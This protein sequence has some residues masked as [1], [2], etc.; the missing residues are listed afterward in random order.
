MLVI[1]FPYCP[2]ILLDDNFIV[3]KGYQPKKCILDRRG[4]G[5]IFTLCLHIYID[6]RADQ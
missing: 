6:R 2:N 3:G 4:K 5:S 1:L